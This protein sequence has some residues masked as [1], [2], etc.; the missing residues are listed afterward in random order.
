MFLCT[1]CRLAKGIHLRFITY[2]YNLKFAKFEASFI[3]QNIGDERL[4]WNKHGKAINFFCRMQNIK[5]FKMFVESLISSHVIC[6]FSWKIDHTVVTFWSFMIRPEAR[7][8]PRRAITNLEIFLPVPALL[9]RSNR[10]QIS[11]VFFLT[12][13]CI[14]CFQ[15]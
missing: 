10:L 4:M 11:E 9:I 2:Y 7:W 15:I 3:T 14:L 8:E 5:I 1:F 13:L 12:F 6:E